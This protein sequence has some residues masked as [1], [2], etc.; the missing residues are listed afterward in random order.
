MC[1]AL[2]AK[3]YSCLD[4]MRAVLGDSMPDSLLNQAAIRCGFDAQKALDAVLSEDPK[5]APAPNRTG[6]DVEKAPL[7]QRSR[8]AAVTEK[9]S[10]SCFQFEHWEIVIKTTF[11]QDNAF[12]LSRFFLFFFFFDRLNVQFL[13]SS[14]I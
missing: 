7:P 6:A 5:R 2:T 3:L 1:C 9:G 4:H 12:A 13:F 14:Y 8:Q 10:C 11:L